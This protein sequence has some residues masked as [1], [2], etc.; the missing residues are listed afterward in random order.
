M[1]EL[2]RKQD[3]EELRRR[4][5]ASR[6]SVGTGKFIQEPT[7]SINLNF[8]AKKMSAFRHVKRKC[9]KERTHSLRVFL[10]TICLNNVNEKLILKI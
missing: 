4:E 6:H 10:Q 7:F 2:K 9:D 1:K 8:P 3:E 5:E